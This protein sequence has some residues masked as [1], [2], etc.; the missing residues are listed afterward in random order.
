ME[1]LCFSFNTLDLHFGRKVIEAQHE[2]TGDLA[3]SL[4][5]VTTT[6]DGY[7]DDIRYL[8]PDPGLIFEDT[9]S[10]PKFHALNQA[11]V[12]LVS[13]CLRSRRGS[14][15]SA[16]LSGMSIVTLTK[17]QIESQNIVSFLPLDSTNE[18]SLNTILSHIDNM[19]QYGEDEEPKA[20]LVLP[21]R[22]SKEIELIPIGAQRHG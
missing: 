12:S 1:K 8:D 16:L 4:L 6:P 19:M 5:C 21:C 18:D 9:N 13:P 2:D 3:E 20:S 10:N 7:T 22:T 15:H 14:S 11:V 17:A